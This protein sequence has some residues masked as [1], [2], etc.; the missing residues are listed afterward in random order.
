MF[1][2]TSKETYPVLLLRDIVIFPGMIAPLFVG[3][4][5]SVSALEAALASNRKIFLVTQQSPT[6]DDPPVDKIYKTGIVCSILQLLKLPD[7][8][9]KAL[10]EGEVRANIKNY[11]QGDSH[12][13]AEV[14]PLREI[15]ANNSAAEP[16]MRMIIK[17]FGDYLKLNRKI[18]PEMLT[19][20][21]NSGTISPRP[22]CPR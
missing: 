17:Q 3:R 13:S 18:P 16:L 2:R 10:I 15:P 19:A 9:V 5:R 11:I 21:S 22:N 14:I 4:A 7:G 1:K 12:S 20:R 6:E 8:T